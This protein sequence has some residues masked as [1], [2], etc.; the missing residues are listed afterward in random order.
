MASAPIKICIVGQNASYKYGGEASLPWLCFKYLRER[1]ID[2]HLVVH[3][4]TKPEVLAG[5]PNDHD[6]LHFSPETKLDRFLWRCGSF[7][8]KKIDV[9]TFTAARHIHNQRLQ[10]KIVRQL[11]ADKGIQLVHEINPVSP[12]Q[13]SRMHGLGVPVIIGPL[14]GGMTYPRAFRDMESRGSRAVEAVGRGLSRILNRI[15]P[16]KRQAAALIVA[17]EQSRQ[18]L[19][20]GV[21]G[22]IFEIPDVGVD[23][24][25]WNQ[26]E[27]LPPRTDDKIRFVYLGRLTDWKGIKF[28]IS[29]FKTV[30]D[31]EPRA[32]LDILGDG[33]ERQS[34]ENLTQQLNLTDRVTFA[35]W[36]SAAEG[37]RRMRQADVF[38]LPSLREVGGIVLLEAMAVGL[39]V[40]TTNWGGP[41]I[42]VTDATGIRVPPTSRQDF[43]QG[44]ADAMLRL[45]NSPELRHQMGQ[46][47]LQ[48]VR[49]NLYD[50]NQKTDRLLEIYADLIAES[51]LPSPRP[52]TPGSGPG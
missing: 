32:M 37:S 51:R 3:G 9:Q 7:L 26:L 33:E 45:A 21:R 31:R 30:A 42:H 38:V 16:G 43:I 28:L 52:G 24:S 27:T 13:I 39:P 35:G 20:S 17:N 50:W 1:G 12:K 19:P 8:P 6:R 34:L 36:V 41:A 2:V 25:V 10:R 5:F 23:L 11:I 49:T 4:R 14:A 47:G 40:I 48:R 18:A 46:A 15:Y 22:K 29:A 44:L